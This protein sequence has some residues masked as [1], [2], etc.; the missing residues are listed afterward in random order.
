MPKPDA[1]PVTM[2]IA[3]INDSYAMAQILTRPMR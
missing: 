3:V 1:H 2:P